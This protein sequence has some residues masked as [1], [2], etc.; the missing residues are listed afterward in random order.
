L[1]SF[2]L[3]YYYSGGGQEKQLVAAKKSPRP[4][5]LLKV[6]DLPEEGTNRSL[7][8]KARYHRTLANSVLTETKLSPK[9][10]LGQQNRVY[11]KIWDWNSGDINSGINSW[12]NYSSNISSVCNNLPA[13]VSTVSVVTTLPIFILEKFMS[14]LTR[15]IYLVQGL[16][17]DQTKRMSGGGSMPPTHM[18]SASMRFP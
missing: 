11:A 10:N 5:G 1:H 8:Q 15:Q 18:N 9:L 12:Q 7:Y 13:C 2:I 16:D 3:Q 6:A 14:R 17:T 4:F